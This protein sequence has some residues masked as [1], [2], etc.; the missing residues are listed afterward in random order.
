MQ[1][2]PKCGNKVKEDDKFCGKCGNTVERPNEDIRPLEGEESIEIVSSEGI[3]TL[4]RDRELSRLSGSK[5]EKYLTD[6]EKL[7]FTTKSPVQAGGEQQLHGY[8]TDSRV[9][10]YGRKGFII[11]SDRFIEI[12]FEQIKSYKMVETGTIFKK[13]QLEIND[14]RV[15]GSRSDILRLYK[16]IQ[17]QKVA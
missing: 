14:L 6:G 17:T 1:Y 11:K 3:S 7:F 8:V 9:I 13:M 12:P 2:C 4:E 5:L 10:F 16:A 15:D